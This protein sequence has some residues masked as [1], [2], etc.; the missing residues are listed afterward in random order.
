LFGGLGRDVIKGD[1][2]NDMIAGGLDDDSDFHGAALSGGPGND[3]LVGGPGSDDMNGGP[4]RNAVLAKESDLGS[5]DEI[6]RIVDCGQTS[7][8]SPSYVTLSP[9]QDADRDTE[10]ADNCS[11]PPPI[12]PTVADLLR[13]LPPVDGH[14][15]WFG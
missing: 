10:T 4:G 1:V 11:G 3:T 8:A 15:P 5:A 6:D 14:W 12:V 9:I 13:T 7:D 2:G